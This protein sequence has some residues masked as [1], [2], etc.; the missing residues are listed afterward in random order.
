MPKGEQII[1]IVLSTIFLPILLIELFIF[2]KLLKR[3]KI[4]FKKIIRYNLFL[5]LISALCILILNHTNYLDYEKPIPFRKFNT[6]NFKNF[7]GLGLF[8]RNLLGNKHFAYVVTS[9]DY[10]IEKDYINIE[11][12]FHP[13]RSFVYNKNTN[14]SELL[15]HELYH[16]KIT[17]IF[18]RKAR[19]KI[20]TINNL[21]EE[22]TGKIINDFKF[23]EN[24]FQ[25]KYDYETHH[26]Y[27]YSKQVKYQKL[28]DSTLISLNEFKKTKILI[29]EKK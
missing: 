2:L 22:S 23:L 14:S 19:K 18:A 10:E 12:Y 1:V 24:E 16:F 21:S 3:P 5:L 28:I 26:S 25:K 9:I 8:K 13:S 17:E 7:R 20:S 27:I 29:H 6:I 15:T 4:N 11:A